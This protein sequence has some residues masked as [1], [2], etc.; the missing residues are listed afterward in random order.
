MIE[1]YQRA[2]GLETAVD[3]TG[4]E[5]AGLAHYVQRIR[6]TL[7]SQL[8]LEMGFI[9]EL[10]ANLQRKPERLTTIGAE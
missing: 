6:P 10:L 1:K 5:V 3:E 7:E 8:S 9:N 4:F 2:F